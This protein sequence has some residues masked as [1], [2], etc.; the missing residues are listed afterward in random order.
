MGTAP[1]LSCRYQGM[2]YIR[3]K[4]LGCSS[5]HGLVI[6]SSSSQPLNS[7]VEFA[8]SFVCRRIIPGSAEDHSNS[9]GGP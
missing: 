2:A 9:L 4:D 6:P 8:V 7:A 5:P 1:A 3:R